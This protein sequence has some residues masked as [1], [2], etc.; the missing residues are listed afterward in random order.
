[1]SED[2]KKVKDEI[3][4]IL[5]AEDAEVKTEE[6][7]TPVKKKANRVIAKPDDWKEMAD[8]F[9]SSYEALGEN[10]DMENE[11]VKNHLIKYNRFEKICRQQI[12]M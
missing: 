5:P 1:M 2:T 9:K 4:D 3:E 10:P 11:L 12:K 6:K 7:K 8:V